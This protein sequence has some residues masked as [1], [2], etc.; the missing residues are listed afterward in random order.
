[1]TEKYENKIIDKNY[2][3]QW[4]N[5]VQ[6]QWDKLDEETRAK[7]EGFGGSKKVEAIPRYI[8]SECEEVISGQNNTWIVLGRDRPASIAS[9]HGGDGSTGAGSIDICVGRASREAKD[10]T[11]D[12]KPLYVDN[13]FKADAARIYISQKTAVD[14]NFGLRPGFQ[15]SAFPRSAIALKADLVRIVARE[16]I[17]L[18]TRTD[19]VNSQS[20]AVGIIGGIDLIAG[21]DDKDMQPLV[22]GHNLRELLFYMIQDIASVTQMVHDIVLTQQVFEGILATHT[23]IAVGPPPVSAPIGIA[24]PS[25]ELAIAAAVKSCK[26]LIQD[27]PSHIMSVINNIM[28]RFKYITPGIGSYICSDANN[29]N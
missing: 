22:K 7:L 19:D 24:L 16:N 15:G 12:G 26:T 6:S 28:L 4:S 18:V 1:M 25:G 14:K 21:N 23:H 3:D 27:Y 17:K 2:V 11:E 5:F 29:T 10:S 20:G 9:G 8:Q 13:D